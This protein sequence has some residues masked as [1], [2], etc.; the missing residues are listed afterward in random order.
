META[1]GTATTDREVSS[2]GSELQQLA[3]GAR[4]AV[5]MSLTFFAT[6]AAALTTNRVVVITGANKGIGKEIAKRIGSLADHTV[7]LACRDEQLGLATTKEL[8]AEGCSSIAFS[9]LDLTDASTI[10]ATAK[11]VES[12]YGRCDALVNNAAIC[13][14]DATL[15]GKV[16][17]TPFEQQAAITIQTNYFGTLKVTESL[18]PLL[19]A[20]SASPRIVNVASAAGRLRGSPEIQEAISNPELSVEALS[21]MMESFVSDAEQGTHLDAGWP[22]TC[23]GVSKMG[24]IALTRIMARDESAIM[25][26]SAD[27]GFCA[28]D[29]NNNQG[30]I[31]AAQGAVTPAL[32]AYAAFGGDDADQFVSGRH[33]YEG[34]EMSWTYE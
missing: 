24:L 15:Y 10:E 1:R 5:V 14:N 11:F 2:K 31:S 17:Y 33:F 13:F 23:Y 18:L 20:S 26:N 21:K 16:D 28:T 12:E 4:D 29:Q 22:N 6:T 27:P 32:L 3:A 30:Y 9:K 25:V 7:V 19:R 34:R 8:E